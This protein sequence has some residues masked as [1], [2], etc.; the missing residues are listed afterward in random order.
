MPDRGNTPGI[1]PE[2]LGKTMNILIISISRPIIEPSVSLNQVYS[3]TATS[4]LSMFVIVIFNSFFFNYLTESTS[5]N[6]RAVVPCAFS[7]LPP[8][9]HCHS[10]EGENIKT[11][12]ESL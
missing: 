10:D 3:V 9:H 7:F 11:K 2:R 8:C 12:K 4:A 6:V 5:R 1:Y